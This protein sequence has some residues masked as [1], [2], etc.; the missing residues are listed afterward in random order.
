MH[1]NGVL[2]KGGNKLNLRCTCTCTVSGVREGVFSRK[3][4]EKGIFKGG[5]RG[6]RRLMNVECNDVQQW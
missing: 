3:E 6:K 1:Q 5:N 4:T 2:G